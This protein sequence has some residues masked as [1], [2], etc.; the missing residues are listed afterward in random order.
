MAAW[1]EETIQ[2]RVDRG[3]AL[4]DAE[5]PGWVQ[6]IDLD[7]FRMSS[8]SRCI[9]GQLFGSFENGLDELHL[10]SRVDSPEGFDIVTPEDEYAAFTAAW[11]Q[12][13]IRRREQSR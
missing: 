4:L 13:I 10:R 12:L 8:C 2:E 9:L 11:K 3:A 5:I 1:T 6:R 7:R